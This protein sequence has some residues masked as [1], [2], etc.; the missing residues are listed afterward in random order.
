[1]RIVFVDSIKDIIGSGDDGVTTTH[2][3]FNSLYSITKHAWIG[4]GNVAKWISMI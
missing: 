2:G 4:A 3:V 1:M